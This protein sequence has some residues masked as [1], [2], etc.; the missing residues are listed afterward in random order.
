MKKV[1]QNFTKKLNGSE[2]VKKS[3]LGLFLKGGAVVLNYLFIYSISKLYGVSEWGSM[4]IA[5]SIINILSVFG[6]LGVDTAILKFAS[7]FHQD[8]Q[9]Y[10][11][12]YFKGIFFIG[13]LSLLLSSLLYFFSEEI[14]INVFNKPYITSHI[15]KASFGILPFCLIFFNGQM[16]RAKKRTNQYFLFT[17]VFRYL[18]P[19][20]GILIIFIFFPNSSFDPLTI[21]ICS[22]YFTL[23]VSTLIILRRINFTSRIAKTSYLDIFKTSAPLF[24]GSSALLIMGWVDTFM[25]G[26]YCSS[27][28]TGT[29]NILVK[30]SQVPSIV[31]VAVNGILA[32]KISQYFNNEKID[33]FRSI[34]RQSSKL[35]FLTSTPLVM[36]TI[37]GSGLIF[38]MFKLNGENLLLVYLI[39]ILGQLVNILSGSVGLILQMIGEQR[40][41]SVIMFLG[42]TINILLNAM[43]I[44]KFGI[45][46]AS[47]ATAISLAIWNIISVYTVF[48]T[49]KV[50]TV[51]FINP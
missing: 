51:Y 26:Q 38:N 36:F 4:A 18:L 33:E 32:P 8:D 43:L 25:I 14:A 13:G 5:I 50:S 48:H 42:L 35:I 49:T 17:D 23:L 47:I 37:I 45:L 44:P 41:F 21:F 15:E 3:L 12:L 31:L 1:T 9:E 20:V 30:V 22:L 19:V 16:F 29:Y 2:L 39:L 11:S 6:R 7:T 24:L 46:G 27:E 10:S 34:V 28:E 40:K